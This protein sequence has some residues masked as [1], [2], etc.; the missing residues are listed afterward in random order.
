M[1]TQSILTIGIITWVISG[2][3][4]LAI[5]RSKGRSNWGGF[6][7][8]FL[9]ALI[10][11]SDQHGLNQQRFKLGELAQCPYCK[12][13]INSDAT[14]CKHCHQSLPPGTVLIYSKAPLTKSQTAVSLIPGIALI[15]VGAY[16]FLRMPTQLIYSITLLGIGGLWLIILTIIKG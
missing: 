10:V 15:I 13:L 16:V 7:L 11:K 4:T 12:E 14:I 1:D 8:G 9:I 2:F 3:I 5:F 6:A